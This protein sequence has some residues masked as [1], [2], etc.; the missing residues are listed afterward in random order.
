MAGEI[1]RYAITTHSPRIGVEANAPAFA[2][3]LIQGVRLLGEEIRAARPDA[4][5]LMS[6]HWVTTFPWY[7]T[8][9]EVLEGHC[10][11]DEAPDLIPGIP[12]RWQGD[13]LLARSIVDEIKSIGV[14]AAYNESPHYEL[15]YGTV[16]PM[17]YLDPQMS[18]PLV[19]LGTCILAPL[20]ECLAVGAAIRRAVEKTGRRV[21]VVGSTAFAHLIERGPDKWPPKEHM[22]E[23]ARFIAM[24]TA[25]RIREAKDRLPAYSRAV[26]AEVGGRVIGTILGTLDEARERYTGVQHGP[27]GQSSA[28]GNASVSLRAVH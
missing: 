21:A 11:A 9:Q 7:T 15:D 18:V 20:D 8:C 26:H 3:G 14:S 1:V 10:V 28:S 27:Y 5:V 24:L 23:D 4:I 16:V 19:S 22:E 2:R 6:T 17:Q 25:G 12:Y 13:P